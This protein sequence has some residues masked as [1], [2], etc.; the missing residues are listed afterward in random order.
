MLIV[1]R[2]EQK[3]DSLRGNA[4]ALVS[5][6]THS[7]LLSAPT[8][9]LSSSAA[10]PGSDR[11][12]FG[13]SQSSTMV[14][15]SS[16]DVIAVTTRSAWKKQE[17]AE[18]G[19]K[20]NLQAPAL[21]PSSSTS[22]LNLLEKETKKRKEPEN[23]TFPARKTKKSRSPPIIEVTAPPPVVPQP[24]AKKRATSS[25]PS[26]RQSS[27][28]RTLVS[29]PEPEYQSSR[30][31]SVSSFHPPETPIIRPCSITEDGTPGPGFISNEDV[32]RNLLSNY[33]GCTQFFI[34]L[35]VTRH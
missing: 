35:G 31:R 19:T 18:W 32:V 26:S 6:P 25:L 8:I 7:C 1:I 22:S 2:D 11:D 13:Q 4:A 20:L 28:P 17:A 5:S 27:R 14:A 10:A 24:K 3:R 16:L 30:S 12:F 9:M 33:K 23:P 29:S 34:P 15:S 21:T